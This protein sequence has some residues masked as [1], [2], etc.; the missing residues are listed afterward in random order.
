M[1]LIDTNKE[2]RFDKL[3]E[4][5]LDG[6][7]KV[8]LSTE[9]GS[10]IIHYTGDDYEG[11]TIDE[12]GIANLLADLIVS[13]HLPNNNVIE[14]MRNDG[15]LEDYERGSY[16]FEEFVAGVIRDEWY[17]YLDVS[18]E[19]YD[20]KRGYTSVKAEMDITLNELLRA[21]NKSPHVFSNWDV[22]VQTPM[23]TLKVE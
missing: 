15:D 14:E 3:R 21:D 19:H 8:T 7:S 12:T 5:N 22:E 20:H 2:S 17:E 9:G 23:G 4:M 11:Q 16:N 10:E 18:T 6:N 1:K 13:P